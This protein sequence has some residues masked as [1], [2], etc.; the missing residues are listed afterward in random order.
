MVGISTINWGTVIV[1]ILGS[2]LVSTYSIHRELKLQRK[3]DREREIEGWYHKLISTSLRIKKQSLRLPYNE[4]IDPQTMKATDELEP[5]TRI[6]K[7]IEVLLD[8]HADAPPEIE[9][10]LLTDIEEIGFWWENPI[11]EDE[12]NSTEMR[13]FLIENSEELME[14]AVEKSDRYQGLPY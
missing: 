1:S 9:T 14:D 12:F 7:N 13:S 4:S 2:I 3:Y 6:N 5:L 8:L 10:D 11:Q